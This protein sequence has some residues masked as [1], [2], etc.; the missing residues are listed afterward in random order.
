MPIN[1]TP[2]H[3][4]IADKLNISLRDA[5]FFR[6]C[7]FDGYLSKKLIAGKIQNKLPGL[8]A[9]KSWRYSVYLNRLSSISKISDE[10]FKL[11]TVKYHET[12]ND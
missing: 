4:K 5:K 6:A 10:D 3:Q 12:K 11:L 1:Y 2:F 7:Y 8:K 9:N